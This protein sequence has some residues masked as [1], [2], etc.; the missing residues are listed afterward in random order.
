MIFDPRNMTYEGAGL[1]ITND[2]SWMMVSTPLRATSMIATS[3]YLRSGSSFLWN[4]EMPEFPMNA[5]AQ[6]YPPNSIA[7]F[8]STTDIPNNSQIYVMGNYWHQGTGALHWFYQQSGGALIEFPHHDIHCSS[9]YRRRKQLPIRIPSQIF[10]EFH[11]DYHPVSTAY[12]STSRQ[13]DH[14]DRVL[15]K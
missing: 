4:Y 15:K 3:I 8:D 7:M 10:Q 6:P 2:A 1:A 13:F 14:S 9:G 11:G 5:S 12:Y